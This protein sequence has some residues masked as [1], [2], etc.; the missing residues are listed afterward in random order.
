MSKLSV[1]Y[2]HTKKQ[3]KRTDIINKTEDLLSICQELEKAHAYLMLLSFKNVGNL[4]FF[5]LHAEQLCPLWTSFGR[6]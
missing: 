6:T 4:Y 3:R 5:N 2:R 1:S